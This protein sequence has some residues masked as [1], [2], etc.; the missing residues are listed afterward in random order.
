MSLINNAHAG[1]QI[2]LM[3]LLYRT[4]VRS[5]GGMQQSELLSLCRPETL[6][7]KDDHWKRLTGEIKFWSKPEHALWHIDGDDNITLVNDTESTTPLVAEISDIVRQVI[8]SMPLESIFEQGGVDG[9]DQLMRILC[10]L[11]A[12]DRFVPPHGSLLDKNSLRG[13]IED[14]CSG[15]YALNDSEIPKFLEYALFLGFIIP[16]GSGYCVD[17]TY[18]VAAQLPSLFSSDKEIDA[19]EFVE[20]LSSHLPVFDRGMLREEVEDIMVRKGWKKSIRSKLSPSLSHVL[21]SLR[22]N[23]L[24]N[25][26]SIS[27]H[28]GLVTLSTERQ[29]STIRQAKVGSD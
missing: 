5:K 18:V 16:I 8:F 27:D 21:E 23:H 10:L 1:S 2:N 14:Y 11:L 7:T 28:P 12:T 26:H 22:V 9:I 13:L 19:V 4:L 24:I 6:P 15:E 17:P 20:R 29:I 3:C 25:T